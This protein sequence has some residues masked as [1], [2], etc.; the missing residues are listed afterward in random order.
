M[1]KEI[2]VILVNRVVGKKRIIGKMEGQGGGEAQR[3]A[4]PHL[5]PHTKKV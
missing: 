3:V 4:D 2:P 1:C 5:P